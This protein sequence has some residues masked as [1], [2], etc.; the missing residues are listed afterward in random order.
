MRILAVPAAL[1]LACCLYLPVPR[2]AAGLHRALEALYAAVLRLF[3]R[4]C[5]QTDDAPALLTLSLLLGGAAALLGAAHPLL[6]AV[7]AAPAF[8]GLAALPGCAAVKDAL[9]SG[10]YA[11]DIP[12]YESRVRETCASLAPA[13]T[14]GVAAPL[15]L[16]AAGTPLY[17]GP[18]LC[19]IFTAL[20][21]FEDRST[22]ARRI[23]RAVLRAAESILSALMLLC[24]GVVGRNPL[25]TQG[26]GAQDRLLHILGVAGD[27]TDTHAPMSGDIAQGIFLCGFCT[28]LLCLT[29]TAVGFILC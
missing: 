7:L 22:A 11:R 4:R 9:D 8:T 21:L 10:Q 23:V 25:R 1:L 16:L 27:G 13:F 14:A 20:R 17:L 18:S 26:R 29:L 2:A 3:T 24:S 12:A 15:L 5:G 6:S 19:W 28:A